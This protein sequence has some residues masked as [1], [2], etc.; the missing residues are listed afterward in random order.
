MSGSIRDTIVGAYVEIE[1]AIDKVTI[2][3]AYA[4]TELRQVDVTIVGMYVEVQE[5]EMLY[6][7]VILPEGIGAKYQNVPIIILTKR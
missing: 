1:Q 5:E 2:V 6:D 3:G 4:E 7:T